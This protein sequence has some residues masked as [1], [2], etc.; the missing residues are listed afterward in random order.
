M[1]WTAPCPAP[2]PGLV[3]VGRSPTMCLRWRPR[4]AGFSGDGLF[5]AG[6]CHVAELESTPVDLGMRGYLNCAEPPVRLRDG[7]PMGKTGRKRRARRKN[8]ANHGKRPNA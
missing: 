7:G 6:T 4:G 2:G 3:V 5:G 8:A 1:R